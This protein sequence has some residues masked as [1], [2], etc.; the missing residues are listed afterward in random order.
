MS[1]SPSV[2]RTIDRTAQAEREWID[3]EAERRRARFDKRKP[4]LDQDRRIRRAEMTLLELHRHAIERQAKISSVSA[5]PVGRSSPNSERQRPGP[6]AQQQLD[7]DPRWREAWK[8]IRRRFE[9]VHRLLDEAEGL[10]PSA[11]ASLLS[12]E[13]DRLILTEGRGHSCQAVV[14]LLGREV[15]GSART[16]FRVRREKAEGVLGHAVS[17]ID[18]ERLE[19]L[20]EKPGVRRVRID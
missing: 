10:G 15:A 16:V 3:E 6:P 14:D 13:K 8:V 5:G 11:V 17:T 20:R 9:D 1:D 2:E 7:D 19:D 18:G 12:D 4:Q